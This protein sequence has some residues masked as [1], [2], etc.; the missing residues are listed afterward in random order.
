MTDMTLDPPGSI[1]IVGTTAVGLEAALY[2]RYLG[3]DVHVVAGADRWRRRED[4]IDDVLARIGPR[5]E[6]DW[7]DQRW[8]KGRDLATV[9]DEAMPMMPDQCLSPLARAAV[10][11]QSGDSIPA[12]LPI[13]MRE[14]IEDALL[15]LTQTDL[16]RDR[17]DTHGMIEAIRLLAI[18]D[19]ED[20]DERLVDEV[21]AIQES[22]PPDFEIDL[23]RRGIEDSDESRP[24]LE[25]HRYECVIVADMPS[26]AIVPPVESPDYWFMIETMDTN[27]AETML[28]DS[29]RQITRIFATLAGR[30]EL[31]LYRPLRA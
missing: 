31:D 11:T 16:L 29:Q 21:H 24:L 5:F 2:G 18:D 1:L 9:I 28:R 12:S 6:G 7:F 22:I 27:D 23:V 20:A 19:L 15:P 10:Q 26:D 30:S 13:T 3:Y 8:L 17:V 14:W 4:V 25:T